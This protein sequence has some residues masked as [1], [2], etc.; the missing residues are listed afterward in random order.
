MTLLRWLMIL[1]VC[2]SGEA[3]TSIDAVLVNDI[4]FAALRSAEVL[5]V[6]GK[7][8]RPIKLVFEWSSINQFG[9]HIVKAAPL[10]LDDCRCDSVSEPP[11]SW[12][13]HSKNE[14]DQHTDPESKWNVVNEFL[15]KTL[16]AKGARWGDG[17]RNRGQNDRPKAAV[18]RTVTQ[19][20]WLVCAV[21]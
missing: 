6:F 3:C 15:Q 1:H 19:C 9:F 7:Q 13:D 20:Y 11:M 21:V 14:F 12:G 16:I 18:L 2:W 4:A 5:Q 8:H 10:L 17:Q